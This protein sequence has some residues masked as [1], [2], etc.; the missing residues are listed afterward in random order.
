[1]SNKDGQV[2]P[3]KDL[4]R[5]LGG[6]EEALSLKFAETAGLHSRYLNPF[7]VW[8]SRFIGFDKKF[9]RAS[10]CYLFDQDNARYLDFMAGFG[11]LNLG[12]EPPQVLKALKT[13]EHYPNILQSY[14]NPLAGKLAEYLA[15]LTSG[16]LS[17]AFF[18]NSGTEGCEAAI[19]LARASTGKKTLVYA[20]GAFHGKTMGSLSVSGREKYKTPFAPLLPET[21]CVPYGDEQA[22]EAA[23]KK[24]DAA[25]FIV[26]PIQG[27]AGVIVPKEGYLKSAR[28]LCDRYGALLILDEVQTGMGRTGRLFCYEYEEIVPDILV[29]SKSLGG[30]VIPIGAMLAKDQIWRRAYG[31]L[32][33]CLLH[34]STFGGNVKAMACG[35][36]AIQ[37]LISEDLIQNAAQMGELLL[38][39]LE[40][41]RKR[42][43]ILKSVRGK[44]LM[45]GMSL[46]K[47]KGK[48]SLME[49]ALSLWIVRRLFKRHRIITAFT[50]NNYDVLRIA[51]PLIVSRD[52]VDYFLEAMEDVLKSAQKFSALRLVKQEQ[53]V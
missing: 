32:E 35:I 29:L 12:H 3:Y 48:K 9:V 42:F 7:L 14:L 30:G 23:L 39:R 43:S 25:A 2:N 17:R 16:K 51:P 1:M 11:A 53:E 24:G 50:L 19:K 41:M 6:V 5:G 4:I 36:A 20:E 38:E 45:I 26:E 34:T 8:I 46:A 27:E 10:G 47:L 33:K 37:A 21:T 13:V 18:C 52:D 15:R 22:L 44:G 28:Q 40:P 31:S 49:G